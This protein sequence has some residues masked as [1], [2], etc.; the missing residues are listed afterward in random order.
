MRELESRTFVQCC[1]CGKVHNVKRKY[2]EEALYIESTCPKC[3]H[4]KA[5]NLG[6]DEN[7]LYLYLDVNLCERYYL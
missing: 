5:L 3:G 2:D 1:R 4:D 6:E 7:D